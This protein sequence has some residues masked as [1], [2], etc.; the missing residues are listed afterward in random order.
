MKGVH[1]NDADSYHFVLS[2]MTLNK[3][4]SSWNWGNQKLVLILITNM[5]KKEGKKVSV[6]QDKIS[7]KYNQQGSFGNSN[8]TLS[9]KSSLMF[10]EVGDILIYLG[11]DEVWSNGKWV[12]EGTVVEIER[13]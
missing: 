12:Q 9:L 2:I 13:V 4:L 3:V 5:K 8:K 1:G 11:K 7:S 10:G 6:F